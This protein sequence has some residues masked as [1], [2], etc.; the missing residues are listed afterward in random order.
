M[1]L[2]LLYLIHSP[3]TRS[4]GRAAT[5]SFFIGSIGKSGCG[6]PRNCGTAMQLKIF[7]LFINKNDHRMPRSCVA[8]DGRW[9]FDFSLGIRREDK[10]A[11]FCLTSR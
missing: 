4:C 8:G 3:Q 6:A 2:G 7:Y 10:T 9:G 1:S 5:A 11:R